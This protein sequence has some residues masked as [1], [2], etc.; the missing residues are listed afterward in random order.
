MNVLFDLE[1]TLIDS[2]TL[3]IDVL[4][5][6]FA[7]FGVDTINIDMLE[8]IG[9]PL[10][11]TFS[12]YF[13]VDN[14]QSAMNY[15]KSVFENT[16]IRD[17]YAFPQVVEAVKQLKAD[18]HRLYTTSLQI[19]SVVKRELEFLGL[20]ENFTDVAGDSVDTPFTAKT[21]IIENMIK[22]HNLKRN[23]TVVVGDTVF[24]YDAAKQNG[25]DCVLVAWGYGASISQI[26]TATKLIDALKE[27]IR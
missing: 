11:N 17:I 15:Y 9:P 16:E 5:R 3:Q 22:K 25:L 20:L 13:G 24:D 26:D 14:A 1:G 10:I 4:N 19:L 2:K 18:G 21:E 6:V 12:K 8:L 7:H 27:K 23:E